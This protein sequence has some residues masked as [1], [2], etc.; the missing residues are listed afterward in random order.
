MSA[1]PRGVG[2]SA[3]TNAE[4]IVFLRE[5]LGLS[6]RDLARALGVAPITV[7]RWETGANPPTGLSREVLRALHSSV[8]TVAND[9]TKCALVA[10]HIGAGIGALLLWALTALT[11]SQVVPRASR[12]EDVSLRVATDAQLRAEL[13]RR[14]VARAKKGIRK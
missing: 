13:A 3:H 2:G 7:A 12:G 5:A 6:Q 9:A 4:K 8:V 1:R 10:G 14:S 11:Q